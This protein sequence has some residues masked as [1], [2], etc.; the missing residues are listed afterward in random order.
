MY[1]RIAVGIVIAAVLAACS[2]AE[3][4]RKKADECVVGDLFPAFSLAVDYS[5]P[6]EELVSEGGYAEVSN[7]ITSRHFPAGAGQASLTLVLLTFCEE[8]STAEVTALI[9]AN[10][11][12]PADLWELLSFGAEYPSL[13]LPSGPLIEFASAWNGEVIALEEE[14]SG[15]V[16]RAFP[17][18]S[19]WEPD[20]WFTAVSQ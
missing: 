8:L 3:D 2:S 18:D 4:S 10:D 17:L 5:R 19:R 12:E 9:Q 16:L 1:F 7:I 15:R 20:A 13:E 11:L 14:A 6:V